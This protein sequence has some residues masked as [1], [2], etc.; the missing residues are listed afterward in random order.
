M[1]TITLD[2]F[3]PAT[4]LDAAHIVNDDDNHIYAVGR[5]PEARARS[6]EY[7]PQVPD[8]DE[9]TFRAAVRAIVLDMDPGRWY[10]QSDPGRDRAEDEVLTV[11]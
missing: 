10:I 9:D 8:W 1:E 6:G 11:N 7:G 5:E 3:G 4:H 2:Q